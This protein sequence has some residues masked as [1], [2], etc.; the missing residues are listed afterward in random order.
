MFDSVAN[1]FTNSSGTMR[2]ADFLGRTLHWQ[3]RQRWPF[4]PSRGNMH[5]T[6]LCIIPNV[7]QKL[8]AIQSIA[9][10]PSNGRDPAYKSGLYPL[11]NYRVTIRGLTCL[12]SSSNTLSV[13][14]HVVST[15]VT[16]YFAAAAYSSFFFFYPVPSS[17]QRLCNSFSATALSVAKVC[18][19][20]FN[21]PSTIVLHKCSF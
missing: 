7:R 5:E 10:N 2:P 12:G 13:S 11:L 4:E 6:H 1:K 3:T 16:P 15:V 18:L 9:V 19:H 14:I 8:A 17:T 20:C 21:N